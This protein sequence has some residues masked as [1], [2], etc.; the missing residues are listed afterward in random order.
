MKK[1]VLVICESIDLTNGGSVG[2]TK[3]IIN[4]LKNK[5]KIIL[6]TTKLSSKSTNKELTGIKIY[7]LPTSPSI[8]VNK[9]KFINSTL[10]SKSKIKEILNKDKI[11]LIY[12]V[13]TSPISKKIRK[14]SKQ[15]NI[16]FVNHIHT[17]KNLSL[18]MLPKII[19]FNFIGNIIDN[20]LVK[21]Y[22]N[23]DHIIFTGTYDKDFEKDLK[24][25][26]ILYTVISNGIDT[27]KYKKKTNKN[28]LLKKYKL[29]NKKKV[30]YVGRYSPDKNIETLLIACKDIKNYELLVVGHQEI[31]NKLSK[32]FINNN[33]I[34]MGPRNQDELIDIYSI[35]DV[36]VLPSLIELESLVFLEAISCSL[37]I[38]ISDSILNKTSQHMQ[39]N[40]LIF[41]SKDPNDLTKKINSI[42]KDNKL[43]NK[44]GVESRKIAEK[45]DFKKS[46]LK[47]EK[48]FIKLIK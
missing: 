27:T 31:K 9:F 38:I 19:K 10:V 30:L 18:H 4:G 20:Y 3:R 46:I 45:I 43:R 24:D 29:S 1:N 2:Q 33:I 5:F 6:I 32:Y 26:N 48:L 15:L 47:I 28:E 13:H 17:P 22:K 7:E 35:S 21:C 16:P 40:G 34:Y 12:N 25:S 44:M 37:P 36:L 23:S 42:L 41:K 14:I 39:N 8:G 11:N